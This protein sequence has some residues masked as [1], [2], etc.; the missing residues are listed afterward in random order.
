MIRIKNDPLRLIIDY[1]A[2]TE[3][4]KFMLREKLDLQF[5]V[6]FYGKSN[7]DGLEAHDDIQTLEIWPKFQI[8]KIGPDQEKSGHYF[9]VKL[10]GKW[11]SNGLEAE[12]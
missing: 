5:W 3:I 7:R 1:W 8:L 10:Y 6:K 2:K 11:N 4:M 9:W 12:K